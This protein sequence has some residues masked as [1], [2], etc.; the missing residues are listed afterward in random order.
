MTPSVLAAIRAARAAHRP[1]ALVTWL[2]TGAQQLVEPGAAAALDPAIGAAV[3]RALAGDVAIAEGDVL[4]EPFNPP[5]RLIVI[6]A[7]HITAPL[8][9][10]ARLAGFAVTIVEPRRAW[11]T[12]ERFPGETVVRTWP[13]EAVR[14]LAPDVRTAVVTVTHDPKLDDPALVEALRSPAFYVGAL[15]SKKT[16]AARLDRLREA[17][18]DGAA[19]ARL[20][21]GPVGVKIAAR[22]P[23]EIAV[24]I[25]AEVIATLRGAA[26]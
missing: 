22:S 16:H 10:M 11:A 2:D 1:V 13:D 5:L 20:H 26:A 15:G 7:V 25:L 19:L 23:A 6:G 4:V 9:A 24:S 18:L 8:A 12:D 3:T 21:G 17:G 14:A